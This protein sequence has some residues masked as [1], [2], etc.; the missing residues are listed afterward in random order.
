MVLNILAVFRNYASASKNNYRSVWI[1]PIISKTFRRISYL[2]TCLDD[3]LSKFKCCFCK[4]HNAQHCLPTFELWK[5]AADKN[6]VFGAIMSDLWTAFDCLSHSL[7]VA[8]LHVYDLESSLKP[9]QDNYSIVSR[10]QKRILK[11]LF[12]FGSNL[13]RNFHL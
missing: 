1:L 4:G 8:K 12:Y 3:T 13:V 5:E 11:H 10:G 9:L 7:L 2:W 6:K